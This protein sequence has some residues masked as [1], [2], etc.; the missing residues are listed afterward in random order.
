M[1]RDLSM[2]LCVT[3][4]V[5]LLT[6]CGDSAL[7]SGGA[8]RADAAKLEAHVSLAP[9]ALGFSRNGETFLQ[10]GT[11]PA[12]PVDVGSLPNLADLDALTNLSSAADL[13]GFADLSARYGS[14]GFALDLRAQAQIPLIAYGAFLNVPIRWFHATTAEQ[15]GENRYRVATDDPLGRSFELTLEPLANGAIAVNAVLSDMTG[16]SALGWTFDKA[17]D[18]RYLGFGERSDAVD[19]TGKLVENWAEE[20]PFSAGALRP[21]T[22][23]LLGESWQG[24]SPIG[25]TNFPMPWLLSSRGYGFLLDDFSYSAFRLHR[26]SQWNVETRA[27]RMRFVVF[28]GPTPARV[29]SAFVAHNGRQPPPADWFFGPWYQPLGTTEFRRELIPGWREWDIPV[30]VAQT[31]THYLPCAAQSG[32]RDAIREE[33]GLYHR[34]GYKVTTY[35]NSFVCRDHPEGA[36]EEGDAN[37]YFIRT[38]LGS[39]YPIPYLAYTDAS[40]AVIDF[41][42]PD[43]GAWWQSLITQ[44]LDDGY[45]GWM[46]DFGEYVPPDAVTYDGQSGLQYHNRYCTDYHRQSHELTWPRY[47]SDFAQFVRCGNLGTGP[48]ARIVWGGDPS[49]DN[50][51]ADGLG[52]AI[53]QGISMGLSGIAYWGSDIGGFHSLFTGGRTSADTLIRWIEFGAFSGI[54]R[55]QE[56]GYEIPYLQGERV[57][58][59]ED[60]IRPSWRRYT[61]L[62]TQLFP[63]IRAAADE[64]QRSGM[65]IMRHLS[66]MV[67]EDPQAF[68]VAA[69]MQYFFGP[70]LLVAPVVTEGATMRELY[71]PQGPWCEFWAHVRYDEP[72]GAFV[73]REGPGATSGG[74]HVTVDAPLEEIPLFVRAGAVIPLLPAETDTLATIGTVPGLV[75]LDDVRG[76]QTS[77]RFGSNCE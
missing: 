36:Y 3:G 15:I 58:I 32:R 49:E 34:N 60:T 11:G 17:A 55:M 64:Y 20:G 13:N 45:D 12:L 75:D 40:S 26:E 30:T 43:A 50:S 7:Q 44:A 24:P 51:F 10:S 39:T 76:R 21:A 6:A 62:R 33:T 37:G 28:P 35:V 4:L 59:W 69:Q 56:D 23:P 68:S 61:K 22:E 66:L 5:L 16:V 46:E 48:Y 63:Y 8:G 25:G 53:H 57:H 52:A 9:F 65:P 71:L 31:Y 54:M 27:D 38:A 42:H 72:T 70:D 2:K 67:P 73:R 19:Q 18:E 41:T 74:R 47:S 14:L 1:R 77:L 29:L